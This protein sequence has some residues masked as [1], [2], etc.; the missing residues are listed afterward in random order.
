M[1]PAAG[2]GC[3]TS[4][5]ASI[6]TQARRLRDGQPLRVCAS[7]LLAAVLL[8]RY[9]C[10]C[11]CCVFFT[12]THTHTHAPRCTLFTSQSFRT[13]IVPTLSTRASPPAA[14]PCPSAETS[15]SPHHTLSTASEPHTNPASS[16]L[17][18][19]RLLLLSH[20]T[21]PRRPRP[22]QHGLDTTLP[23]QLGRSPSSQP[24]RHWP[25]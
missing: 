16:C 24:E 21:R 1:L 14:H 23:G 6:N 25:Y 4:S 9:C 18:I 15:L 11:C 17:V 12:Y 22:T 13:L 10:C 2:G 8:F 3:G 7:L 5:S 20:P 19:P